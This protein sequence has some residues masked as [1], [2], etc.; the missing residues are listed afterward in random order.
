M[1]RPKAGYYS[2]VA[3]VIGKFSW[4]CGWG[5]WSTNRHREVNPEGVADGYGRAEPLAKPTYSSRVLPLV[6][7][8][9]FVWRTDGDFGLW[10]VG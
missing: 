9:Q 3:V 8:P 6:G 4:G 7:E 1:N 5:L 2:T 10:R